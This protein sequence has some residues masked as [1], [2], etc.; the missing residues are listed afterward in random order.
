ML[1]VR[2]DYVLSSLHLLRVDPTVVLPAAI[3]RQEHSFLIFPNPQYQSWNISRQE[4]LAPG[5]YGISLFR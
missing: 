3:L 2:V 5:T 4:C 1:S